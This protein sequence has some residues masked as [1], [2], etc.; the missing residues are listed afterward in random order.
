MKL[1]KQI[2]ITSY[3]FGMWRKMPSEMI[4]LPM[5]FQQCVCFKQDLSRNIS[6]FHLL[7]TSSEAGFSQLGVLNVQIVYHMP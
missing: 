4:V 5:L 1:E 7:P 3:V 2:E 6:L